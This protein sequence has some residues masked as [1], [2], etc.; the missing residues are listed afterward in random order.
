MIR[1]AAR[2]ATATLTILLAAVSAAH[3]CTVCF[4]PEESTLLDGTKA[5]VWVMLGMT[6]AIQAAFVGF[7]LYLRRRAKLMAAAELDDEWSNLQRA[8]R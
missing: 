8:T 6:M 5:G 7:F 2:I 3:A 1:R 4:G